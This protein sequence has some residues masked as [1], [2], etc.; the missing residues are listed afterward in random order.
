[1]KTEVEFKPWLVQN[2]GSLELFFVTFPWPCNTFSWGPTKVIAHRPS[3]QLLLKKHFISR[4]VRLMVFMANKPANSVLWDKKRCVA[5]HRVDKVYR[6]SNRAFIDAV[7]F[8]LALYKFDYTKKVW[9]NATL[10][11]ELYYDFIHL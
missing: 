6:I 1:M 5:W 9:L 8:S 2:F 3:W 7:D 11:I 4:T 10:E